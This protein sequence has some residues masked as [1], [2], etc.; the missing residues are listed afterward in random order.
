MRRPRGGLSAI[1]ERSS[2]A[3]KGLTLAP[4][5]AMT[6]CGALVPCAK[7]RR[8]LHRCAKGHREASHDQ[9]DRRRPHAPARKVGN[10]TRGW[11]PRRERQSWLRQSA[12]LSRLDGAVSDRGGFPRPP[13]ALPLRPARDAYLGGA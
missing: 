10:P 6:P 5:D 8:W 3:V 11:R 13:R 7:T 1:S 2:T 4:P 9:E 12:R